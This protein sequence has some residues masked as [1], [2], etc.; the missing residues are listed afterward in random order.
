[1]IEALE[2][3]RTVARPGRRR[4]R[5]RRWVG[6]VAAALAIFLL[7]AYSVVRTRYGAFGLAQPI[8]VVLGAPTLASGDTTLGLAI[9]LA[10]QRALIESK[11]V[12]AL[13]VDRVRRT[14]ENMGRSPHARLDSATA[15]EVAEP[16]GAGAIVLA[17]VLTLGGAFQLSAQVLSPNGVLL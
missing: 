7:G 9:Q 12:T 8:T 16:N 10:L 4:S 2:G 6:G 3:R 14:L 15:L 13:P 11:R 5:W 1:M 17:N